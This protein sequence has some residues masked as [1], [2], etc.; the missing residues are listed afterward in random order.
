VQIQRLL[1][2]F[3]L[4]LTAPLFAQIAA[5]GAISTCTTI[6][7]S[8][9]Y[10]VTNN[11]TTTA[12][13][14]QPDLFNGLGCIVITTSDVSLDLGGHTIFGPP[15]GRINGIGVNGIDGTSFDLS[16]ISVSNGV[17]TGFR[18]GVI[19]FGIGHVVEYIRVKNCFDVGILVNLVFEQGG[20]HRIV[21]NTTI[22]N[23]DG[24]MVGCPSVVLENVSFGNSGLQIAPEAPG[25]TLSNNAPAP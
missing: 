1:C 7:Q 8:G 25:C 11:I 17:V 13:N 2:L 14:V 19:L 21:G 16:L 18:N 4:G 10:W 23:T 9:S 20:G 6:N 5:P 12:N 3:L 15:G 22:G 24:I